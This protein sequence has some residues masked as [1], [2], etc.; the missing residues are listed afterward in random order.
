[1]READQLVPLLRGALVRV[2]GELIGSG[3]FVAPGFVLSCA[4]V[5]GTQAGRGGQVLVRWR[6][7]DLSA[8]VAWSSLPAWGRHWPYPDL[9][10]LRVDDPVPEHPC[11]WLDD[12]LPGIGDELI[13][14]AYADR[15]DS[16]AVA[17]TTPVGCGGPWPMGEGDMLQLVDGEIGKGMSGGP[18]L[19]R[20]TGGVVGLVKASRQVDSPRGGL[21]TPVRGLRRADPDVYRKVLRAHDRHH[22]DGSAWTRLLNKAGEARP[23][24]IRPSD[25]RTLLGHLATLP[26]DEDHEARMHRADPLCPEIDERLLDH[27]DVVSELG[28]RPEP[29][30]QLAPVLAYAA[31]LARAYPDPFR[32]A[33]REW[34]LLTADRQQGDEVRR[35]LG[36]AEE[37]DSP[38]S[39]MVRLR[40]SGSN[41]RRYQLTAWRYVDAGRV[42]PALVE[43]QPL[44]LSEAR[45]RLRVLLPQQIAKL[46]DHPAPTMVELFL[47]RNLLDIDVEQWAL[48]PAEDWSILGRRYAVVVRDAARLDETRLRNS[49][50]RRWER[51]ADRDAADCL[52]L[53]ECDDPRSHA[54]VEAWIEAEEKQTVLVFG[55][56]PLSSGVVAL[57][58]G[59]PAGVPVMIWRR[60]GCAACAASTGGCGG[61]FLAHLRR[62]L[63]GTTV[64]RLPHRVRRLRSEAVTSD[65]PDHCGHNIVLLWDDPLRLPPQDRLVL[66]E[67]SGIDV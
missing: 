15:Y 50:R 63:V 24:S 30:G 20:H 29:E 16:G 56:S 58:V 64:D 66:P 34:V 26:V 11:A 3:V 51:L 2:Q 39:V 45:R 44:S 47:P 19:S 57:D 65:D 10:V 25:E 23:V 59:L 52:Y 40:P 37:D 54:Q 48:W 38:T 60:A 67:E 46:A 22:A 12:R 61:D 9:A 18:I 8:T 55:T 6:G 14:V 17:G 27:R 35:R 31:D 36:R 32:K 62:E 49:W 41:R 4:H 33:L 28:G 42:V 1:V 13:A 5:L 43:P 21:A 7:R 53:V